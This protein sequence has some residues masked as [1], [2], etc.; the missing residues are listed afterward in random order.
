MVA[1]SHARC[2]EEELVNLIAT[3]DES[4]SRGV[5]QLE[6]MLDAYPCD[7]RLYYVKGLMLASWAEY[8][9]ACAEMRRAVEL[10]PNYWLAWF[11]LGFLLLKSGRTAEAEKEWQ[12]LIALSPDNYL[13]LFADGLR[14]RARNDFGEAARLLSEGI[15][16]NQEYAPLNPEMKAIVRA[17]SRAASSSTGGPLSQMA[18]WLRHRVASPGA[19]NKGDQ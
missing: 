9:L 13:R 6:R 19:D 17:M 11:Q 18:S 4:D 5:E 15:R 16:N 2:P 7:A 3:I 1:R 14:C 12:Q 10:A 8:G